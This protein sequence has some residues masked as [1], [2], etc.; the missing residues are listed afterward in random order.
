MAKTKT[1][2]RDD[3]DE[4]RRSRRDRGPEPVARDGAYV[5]MLVITLLA[6][7]VGSFLMYKDNEDYGSKQ[8]P[9]EGALTVPKLGD[10]PK[11]GGTATPP[12]P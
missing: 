12:T 3:E 4:D 9:K 8:P 7:L 6:I 2:P 1:R 11:T 5:L 10:Q